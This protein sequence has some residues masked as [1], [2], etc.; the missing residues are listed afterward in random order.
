MNRV[1]RPT[2]W[3]SPILHLPGSV[4]AVYISGPW[5]VEA[6]S[7]YIAGATALEVC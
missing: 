5:C 2:T 6:V 4:F 7:V 3:R 1:M